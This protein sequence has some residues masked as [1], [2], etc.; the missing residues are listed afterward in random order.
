[1]TR[2]LCGALGMISLREQT[3]SAESNGMLRAVQAFKSGMPASITALQLSATGTSKAVMTGGV[4]EAGAQSVVVGE[5]AQQPF[6]HKLSANLDSFRAS[7]Y[8][9][10]TK[11]QV[12]V[13]LSL[14]RS[15]RST[16]ALK[17]QNVDSRR[18][19]FKPVLSP[20]TPI[21][22]SNDYADT[23]LEGDPSHFSHR[24]VLVACASRECGW[25][26]AV[27][28]CGR[29]AQRERDP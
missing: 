12:C 3:P 16:R 17:K 2:E 8:L 4:L 26:T 20:V 9:L 23:G 27:C 15:Y 18:I 7:N 13:R 5:G 11:Q 22:H 25:C 21:C 14:Y 28:T 29:D 19:V 1:M 10:E 6:S 24:G